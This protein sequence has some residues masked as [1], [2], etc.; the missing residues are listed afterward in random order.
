MEESFKPETKFNFDPEE[1]DFGMIPALLFVDWCYD[2]KRLNYD[3]W[4]N[5]QSLLA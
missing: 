4:D 3:D 5:F 1:N 2:R